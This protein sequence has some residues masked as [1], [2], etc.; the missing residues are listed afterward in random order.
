MGQL[1]EVK[2][3]RSKNWWPWRS[4]IMFSDVLLRVL[5]L[6]L[7]MRERLSIYARKMVVRKNAPTPRIGTLFFVLLLSSLV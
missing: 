4:E 6:S 1:D 7:S 2:E 5:S 3:K